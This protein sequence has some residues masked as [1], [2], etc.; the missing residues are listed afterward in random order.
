MVERILGDRDHCPGPRH[1]IVSS[2]RKKGADARKTDRETVDPP[3]F[4]GTAIAKFKTGKEPDRGTGP[5]G[6]RACKTA[7]A[8]S[9]AGR[10][11]IWTWGGKEK[12]ILFVATP[13]GRCLEN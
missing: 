8:Y 10:G 5:T 4:W 2:D 13:S 12:T 3:R 6:R 1:T 9:E 7:N 11:R